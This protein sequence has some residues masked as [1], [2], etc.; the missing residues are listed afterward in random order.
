MKMNGGALFTLDK[1]TKSSFAQP[2]HKLKL[3]LR[4]LQSMLTKSQTQL[5]EP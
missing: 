1:E 2:I 4:V 5:S 3:L